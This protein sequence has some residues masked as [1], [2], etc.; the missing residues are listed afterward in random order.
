M[1][2]PILRGRQYELIALRKCIEDSL[3]SSEFVLPVIEPVKVVPSLIKL[4]GACKE[5][6]F[7]IAIIQNPVVGQWSTSFNLKE[8]SKFKDA[9]EQLLKENE[10]FLIKAYYCTEQLSDTPLDDNSM[11]ICLAISDIQYYRKF[12]LE[13]YISPSAVIFPY[14]RNFLRLKQKVAIELSDNFKRRKNS[15]Y[16]NNDDDFFSQDFFYYKEDRCKGFSDYSIVGQ[17]YTESGFAPTAV[18]I[19][20]VYLKSDSPSDV[21][22]YVHHFVSDDQDGIQDVAKKYIQALKKVKEFDFSKT[23]K[24]DNFSYLEECNETKGL[25]L[26]LDDLDGDEYHGLGVIKQYSIM[27]HLELVNKVLELNKSKEEKALDNDTL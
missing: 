2:Y 15:D 6:N 14:D 8:N 26:M 4:L 23:L 22:L 20:I 10:N 25:K 16:T 18:A 3:I 19:H 13:K 12:I 11:V 7:K 24:N 21:A 9:Y 27:H 17:V 5:N 1:Y